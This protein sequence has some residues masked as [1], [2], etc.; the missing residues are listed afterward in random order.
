M[1]HI[2]TVHASSLTSRCSFRR[3]F[4][5]ARQRSYGKEMFVCPGGGGEGRG[6]YALP[7]VP[8]GGCVFLVPGP[9]WR[10]SLVPSPF[11]GWVCPGG[12]YI[13]GMGTYSPLLTPSGGQHIYR[14][15]AGGMHLT[16]MLYICRGR[17]QNA[18]Q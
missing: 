2:H 5:T 14:R 15:Q 12:G 8:S 17:I 18:I 10:I 9:F 11:R 4:I 13:Q 16:G 6:R 3:L 7:Q 1:E